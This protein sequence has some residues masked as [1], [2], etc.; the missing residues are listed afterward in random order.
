[1]TRRVVLGTII[2]TLAAGPFVISKLRK[3]KNGLPFGE[4]ELFSQNN[5]SKIRAEFFDEWKSDLGK[6]NTIFE[7]D[8][9]KKTINLQWDFSQQQNWNFRALSTQL[10]GDISSLSVC[11]PNNLLSF[12][13]TEGTISID[14]D[15]PKVLVN[16]RISKVWGID[17]GASRK[18]GTKIVDSNPSSD[19]GNSSTKRTVETTDDS[20]LIEKIDTTSLETCGFV[21]KKEGKSVVIR[22]IDKN[23]S[24]ITWTQAK[25]TNYPSPFAGTV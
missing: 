12:E 16:K 6:F 20:Q 24:E 17:D 9:T 25:Q 21:I 4:M 11:T 5:I 19:D 7:K 14:H 1:M 10:F 18:T 13:I 3:K 23:G 2:A 15:T 8:N 22:P